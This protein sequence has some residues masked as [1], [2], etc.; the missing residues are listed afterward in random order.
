[1]SSSKAARSKEIDARDEA[2]DRDVLSPVLAAAPGNVV[3][4]EVVERKAD[5]A[6]FVDFPQNTLGPLLARTLVEDI[7]SG[8]SVLLSFDGGD[9]TR[10]IILGILHER[11]RLAG[12]TLHLKAKRIVLEAEDELLLQ[13]GAGSIEARRDGKV[14]VK[15]R[16]VLSRATRTNKVRGATVLIN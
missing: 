2:P 13:C 4:G 3:S 11:A 10:P 16:D 9:P 8:A 12:R 5:G 14:S 15:G 6:V 7:D 1:M